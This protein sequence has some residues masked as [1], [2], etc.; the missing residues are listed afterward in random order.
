MKTTSDLFCFARHSASDERDERQKKSSMNRILKLH[1]K[2]KRKT[3]KKRDCNNVTHPIPVA[4]FIHSLLHWN[5][6]LIELNWVSS[7]A[8][9]DDSL[10]HY[11]LI[12]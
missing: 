8:A 5:T 10:V 11:Q 9:S 2:H 6:S 3:R 7:S 4:S 1:C 12:S